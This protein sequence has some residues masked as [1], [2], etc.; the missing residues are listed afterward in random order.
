MVLP[1]S[2]STASCVEVGSHERKNA[3]PGVTASAR[4]LPSGAALTTRGTAPDEVGSSSD[5][6][7]RDPSG[8]HAAALTLGPPAAARTS[9]V[10]TAPSGATVR[11]SPAAEPTSKVPGRRDA[12]GGGET[13]SG[14]GDRVAI[15]WCEAADD[16][17]T[18]E[19]GSP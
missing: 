11:R 17:L 3:S 16:G 4:A 2:R 19:L 15:G 9:H 14:A 8:D 10:P 12:E 18:A 5:H 6:A 1:A 13:G 7:I